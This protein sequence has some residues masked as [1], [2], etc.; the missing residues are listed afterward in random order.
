MFSLLELAFDS[1]DDMM[2]YKLLALDRIV[3]WLRQTCSHGSRS[4]KTGYQ[5][6]CCMQTICTRSQC[7]HRSEIGST[8]R[9]HKW[10]HSKAS[11]T[12][13][14]CG[15]AWNSSLTAKHSSAHTD[16][17][18]SN[19][20]AGYCARQQSGTSS[21]SQGLAVPARSNRSLLGGDSA[22]HE[23]VCLACKALHNHCQGYAAGTQS[24]RWAIVIQ[25]LI[26]LTCAQTRN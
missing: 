13:R 14:Y 6:E 19:G 4:H 11:P 17:A 9:P 16:C 15:I 10:W 1:I 22:K 23:S 8:M 2:T 3:R 25:A 24:A 26:F 12:A 18:I 20:C 5:N 21:S 7:N